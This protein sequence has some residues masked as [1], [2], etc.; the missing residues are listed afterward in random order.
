MKIA[1]IV[2]FLNNLAPNFYK[3]SYD[4]VGLLVGNSNNEISNILITLDVTESVLKEAIL[5]DCNLIIAHHPIIFKDLKTLTGSNYVEK[6]VIAAI[7]N[8]VSIV[9]CHTNLDNIFDGVNKKMAEK[10]GLLNLKILSPKI[11]VLKKLSLFVPKE[12]ADILK[13]ALHDAGAGKIGN[14][15]DCAF[16]TEGIGTFMPN[17]KAKPHIGIKNTLEKVEEIKIEVILPTHLEK[18]ILN[19]MRNNH[20]YEEISYYLQNLEN[21]NQEVG[22]GMIGDLPQEMRHEYFLEK[23]KQTFRCKSIKHTKFLKDSI[24]RVALCGGSGSFLLKKAIA[25]NADIFVS[26]D[27]K[28][29][30]FFDAEDK[31][32]I[33]DI[34]HYESEQF[35]KELL[36]DVISKK[37]TNIAPLLSKVNTNPVFYF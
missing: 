24:K 27:F 28:Y 31:I 33:A 9:A 7:K 1:E 8:D 12:K 4:N 13:N 34:G 29:H 6:T 3:E 10:L 26:S 15:S 32:I 14:Y 22:A 36:F 18:N 20:P 2:D 30:E 25:G 5:N 23:V 11:D 17:E 35:T 16:L 37:F 21:E 19:V